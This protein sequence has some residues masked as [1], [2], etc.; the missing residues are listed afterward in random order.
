[1]KFHIIIAQREC[2]YAGQYAPEALEVAD[3]LTM[4][5]YPDWFSGK[6]DYYKNSKEFSSV[7]EIVLEVNDSEIEK[8]LFPDT[9]PVPCEIV[10]GGE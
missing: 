4:D 10:K 9:N 3:G 2:S 6:I 7:K 8:I 5:D 1:M